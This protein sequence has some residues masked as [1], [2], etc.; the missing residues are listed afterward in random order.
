MIALLF[1]HQDNQE[2][3]EEMRRRFLVLFENWKFF[4]IDVIVDDKNDEE[5]RQYQKKWVEI[6]RQ[7]LFTCYNKYFDDFERRQF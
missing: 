1:E 7:E 4:F 2:F 3:R 6:D 5:N